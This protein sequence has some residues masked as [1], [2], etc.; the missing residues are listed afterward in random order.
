LTGIVAFSRIEPASDGPV[1][2]ASD[3]AASRVV[4]SAK[5]G[6]LWCGLERFVCRNPGFGR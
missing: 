6:G 2:R 3:Y 4:T 1:S 5:R